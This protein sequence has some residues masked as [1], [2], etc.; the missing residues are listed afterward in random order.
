MHPLFDWHPAEWASGILVHLDAAS[1]YRDPKLLVTQSYFF[2]YDLRD[3]EACHD[4]TSPIPWMTLSIGHAARA[5][6]HQYMQP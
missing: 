5:T 6:G 3:A 4:T 2:D 1:D